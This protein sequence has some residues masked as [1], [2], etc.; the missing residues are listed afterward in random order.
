MTGVSTTF[1]ETAV[2]AAASAACGLDD[3]GPEPF[4]EPLRVLLA[5][6]GQAPVHPIGAKILH[7]SAVRSL[8]NRLRA[9][10]WLTIHPEIADEVIAAPLVVVG[11]MRS[12]TT[13]IQRLLASDP[14]HYC[15]MGYESLEPAPRPGVAPDEADPR[16]A[17]ALA[18]EKATRELAPDLG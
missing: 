17:D 6:Y 5:A 7:D 4:R 12:G 14:R 8:V 9:R 13:L 1:D 2:L 16:I 3:F 18:R 15:T 10:H 11:M